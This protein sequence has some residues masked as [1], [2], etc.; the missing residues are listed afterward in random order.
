V[1]YIQHGDAVRRIPRTTVHGLVGPTV[2]YTSPT[3]RL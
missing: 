1:R 2:T 3:D